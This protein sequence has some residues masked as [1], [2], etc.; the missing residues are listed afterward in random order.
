MPVI[1][2]IILLLAVFL[3]VGANLAWA[4]QEEDGSAVADLCPI[5]DEAVV[6]D[7][8]NGIVEAGDGASPASVL[9][10]AVV[11]ETDRN[12]GVIALKTV[13]GDDR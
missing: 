9:V 7:H 4:G 11:P 3:F 10:N 2:R 12:L 13:I 6:C 8:G 1:S 5:A